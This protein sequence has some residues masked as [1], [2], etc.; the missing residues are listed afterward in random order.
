MFASMWSDGNP[1]RGPGARRAARAARFGLFVLAGCGVRADVPTTPDVPPAR[2]GIAPADFNPR[3]ACADWTTATEDPAALV[4]D[5]FPEATARGCFTAVRDDADRVTFTAPGAACAYPDAA[6]LDRVSERAAV[7]EVVRDGVP[8][9]V[10][11]ELACALPDD[12][13]R[14]AARQNALTLRAWQEVLARGDGGRHPYA[15][16]STFGYG[17]A[18]QDATPL[19]GYLP[20]GGCRA[21]STRDHEALS[22]NV[23]R[24]RRAARAYH[25]GVAPMVT[26][27]GGAVHAAPIEAFM[28][29]HLLVC[30]EGVPRDRILVDPCADHT[31]TNVRN[32]GALVV[33]V[34]GRFGYVVTDDFLQAAYLQE[35]TGFDLIGG[36]IDQRSLRDFR[37]LVGS[38]R[39]ASTV[40]ASGFWFSPYRFFADPDPEIASLHCVQDRAAMDER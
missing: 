27:S 7:Y 12:V 14:A 15:T 17:N 36:S 6:T 5:A 28:L 40:S 29:L 37:T 8:R 11:L 26:V 3:E 16:V 21:L 34:G 33:G 31:H 20:D 1:V 23:D 19:V 4:H 2:L 30:D 25:G 13:R 32:T 22:V 35:W 38:W 10:P 18:A 39:Q 9:R 24:A